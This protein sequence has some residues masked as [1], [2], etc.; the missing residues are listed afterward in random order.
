MTTSHSSLTQ[1]AGQLL[2]RAKTLDAYIQNQGLP[3][4]SFEND[5]LAEL[6]LEP[7]E[8]CNSVVDLARDMKTLAQGPNGGLF[9]LDI[10]YADLARAVGTDEVLLQRIVRVAMMQRI[11]IE[12][13]D[14]RVQ[15]SAKS[16]ML[17]EDPGAR[18]SCGFFMEELFPASTKF[19]KSLEKYHASG[20][21][22]ETA[23]NL[24]VNTSRSIYLEL[25]EVP[26]RARRF[27]ALMHWMSQ[28]GRLSNEHLLRSFDGA[29]FGGNGARPPAVMVVVGGGHGA[30]FIAP[31]RRYAPH[32]QLVG[33]EGALILVYEFLPGDASVTV[34]CKKHL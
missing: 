25:E 5:S 12:T 18:D 9:E 8:V 14:G 6:P 19:V 17:K 32:A 23:F 1:L 16:R 20:E 13:S 28:D 30:V 15:H 31:G 26:E 10:F 7:E 34:W 22:T 3:P 21:P 4:V 29:K 2:E 11:F 27:G 33:K 24:A